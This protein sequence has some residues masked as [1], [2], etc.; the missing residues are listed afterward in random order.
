MYAA[1]VFSLYTELEL[2]EGFHKW[3]AFYIS[4]STT[5]LE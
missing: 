4:Y 5:K 3:H 2:T 1:E